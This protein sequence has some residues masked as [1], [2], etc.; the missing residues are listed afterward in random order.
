MR[1]SYDALVYSCLI[2]YSPSIALYFWSKVKG[3]QGVA[4]TDLLAV[5]RASAYVVD[6]L[7]MHCILFLLTHVHAYTSAMKEEIADVLSE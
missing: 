5:C 2:Y 6:S 4:V 7:H 3:P 1:K